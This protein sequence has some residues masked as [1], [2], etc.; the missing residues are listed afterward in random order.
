MG[1]WKL[2]ISANL[3]EWGGPKHKKR[4]WL[5]KTGGQ[6]NQETQTTTK[7]T[8]KSS[9]DFPTLCSSR[10]AWGGEHQSPQ[11]STAHPAPAET[12]GG[13]HSHCRAVGSPPAPAFQPTKEINRKLRQT[14][15]APERQWDTT[16][17]C[18]EN[19][20]QEQQDPA[21]AWH[22]TTSPSSLIQHTTSVTPFWSFTTCL[23]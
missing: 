18:L 10:P 7:E 12:P 19:G 4:H 3:G 5:E 14:L 22:I 23:Y 20:Q 1:R 17:D 2:V 9:H 16:N 11:P 15:L 21:G 8:E 13:Q 6:L